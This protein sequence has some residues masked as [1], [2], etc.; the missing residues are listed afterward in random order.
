MLQTRWSVRVNQGRLDLAR[1]D[2]EEAIAILKSMGEEDPLMWLLIDAELEFAAGDPEAA[3]RSTEA[4][5]QRVQIRGQAGVAESEVAHSNLAIFHL[6]GD[7]LAAAGAALERLTMLKRLKS[8]AVGFEAGHFYDS[9]KSAALYAAK[10]SNVRVAARLSAAID[11]AV[12]GVQVPV[13]D[14]GL[15]CR[16]FVRRTLHQML[17]SEFTAEELTALRDEGLSLPINGL[18]EEALSSTIETASR[19][20]RLTV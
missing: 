15:G 18:F 12:G 3:V 7:N 16:A 1:A 14:I 4:L 5:L 9:I 6:A 17:R 13:P 8:S 2:T 19:S 20:D 10:C 11:H